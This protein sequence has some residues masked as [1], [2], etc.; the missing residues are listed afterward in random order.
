M[1]SNRNNTA[2]SVA[3]SDTGKAMTVFGTH[4]RVMIFWVEVVHCSVC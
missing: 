4:T 2:A 1:W 3:S